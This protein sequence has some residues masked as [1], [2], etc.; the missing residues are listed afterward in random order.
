[1]LWNPNFILHISPSWV[2]IRLYAEN[3]LPGMP[4]SALKVPGWWVGLVPTHYQVKLQLML[5][6]SWSRDN[7]SWSAGRTLFTQNKLLVQ[8]LILFI[9]WPCV[10]VIQIYMSD[11]CIL[12][13]FFCYS[14]ISTRWVQLLRREMGPSPQK[15]IKKIWQK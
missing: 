12:F 8:F 10:T 4:G 15:K 1:M 7:L 5:I 14:S 6:L 9:K 13:T 11:K 2:K 3:Q